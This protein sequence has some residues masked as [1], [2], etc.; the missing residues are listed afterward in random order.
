MTNTLAHLQSFSVIR[1]PLVVVSLGCVAQVLSIVI[2]G[3]FTW[4]KVCLHRLQN[5]ISPYALEELEFTPRQ[6]CNISTW[7]QME[8]S[9]VYCTITFL[10]LFVEKYSSKIVFL[11]VLKSLPFIASQAAT[12][13]C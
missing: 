4:H 5:I 7:N 1:I 6:H 12:N 2:S 10:D 3:L 13:T 9:L 11:Q 8:K